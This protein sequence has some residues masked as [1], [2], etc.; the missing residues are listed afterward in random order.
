[1]RE[2]LVDPVL[3]G[4]RAGR[5]EEISLQA[6]APEI[7]RIARANRSVMRG[8]K[9]ERSAGALE[10]GAPPFL[11]LRSGVETLIDRLAQSLTATK[12]LTR[13]PVTELAREGD[14]I[15]IATERDRFTVSGI[16]LCVPAFVAADLLRDLAPDASNALVRIEYASV[17][18]V[19][20]VFQRALDLPAGSGVLVP[21]SAD[22]SI[23][24]CTW[25]SR[26]WPQHAGDKASTSIRCFIGRAGRN[27]LLERDDDQLSKLALTDLQEAIGFDDSPVASTVTRWD[28]SLPQYK[29]G[30]VSVVDEAER[31]LASHPIELAGAGYRGSG[32]PDCIKQGTDAARRLTE[33][34]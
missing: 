3:A 18:G 22:R 29:V 1:L 33:H 32:I 20:F 17:A 27:S 15:V 10:T 4:T 6:A 26:K 34:L 7:D 25:F 5:A 14:Q 8:L 28:R 21:R 2:Q 11:T 24:A 31:A 13:S 9:K 19:S 12:V 30:H 23:S 16:V